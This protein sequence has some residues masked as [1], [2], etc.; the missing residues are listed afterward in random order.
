M[1]GVTQIGCRDFVQLVVNE[2]RPAEMTR[3]QFYLI[4]SLIPDET[5]LGT[6]LQNS[7]LK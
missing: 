2:V 7:P 6:L 3:L 1:K 4:S 5:Y